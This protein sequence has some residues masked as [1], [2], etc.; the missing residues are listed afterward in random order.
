YR[1]L[2]T[3]LSGPGVSG[4]NELLCS[5]NSSCETEFT[6]G[7]AVFALSVA[8]CASGEVGCASAWSRAIISSNSSS[9]VLEPVIPPRATSRLWRAG[10][11]RSRI[12]TWLSRDVSVKKMGS[13]LVVWTFSA[14]RKDP[15][16][17][18]QLWWN[19]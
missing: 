13:R 4:A 16:A 14:M 8:E 2:R 19:R 11:R 17:A 10:F 1:G 15:T 9:L 3:V 12:S 7:G 18:N 5:S 6:S